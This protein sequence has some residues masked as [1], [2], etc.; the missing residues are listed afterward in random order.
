MAAKPPTSKA[1]AKRPARPR[2]A[3]PAPAPQASG[4]ALDFEPPRLTTSTKPAERVTLF[5]ID[6]RE[7]SIEMRPGV[8]V[9]LK[10][11][12]LS[13]TVGE[14]QAMDYLLERLLG[15]EGHQALQ[16]Y[17]DLTQ[18]QFEQICKIASRLTLGALEPPKA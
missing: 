12:H 1:A 9:G 17:D 13:R 7:Y 10:Y 18:E 14:D 15:P 16:D 8:N 11:L 2:P 3:L 6:D 5:Y 4:S